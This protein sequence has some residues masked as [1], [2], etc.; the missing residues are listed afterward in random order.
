MTNEITMNE[1]VPQEVVTQVME[2]VMEEVKVPAATPRVSWKKFGT[3]VLKVGAAVGVGVLIV[4]GVKYVMTKIE[5][6]K[7]A[8]EADFEKPDNVE[9]AKRDFLDE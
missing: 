4:K 9:V 5:E 8:D 2:E 6:K 7:Q 3:G 1:M